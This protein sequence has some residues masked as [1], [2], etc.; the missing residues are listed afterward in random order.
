MQK[1]LDL[2]LFFFNQIDNTN[3]SKLIL[4][5]FLISIS[6]FL[7]F[8]SIGSIIPLLSSLL[9]FNDLE[10]NN[11]FYSI[12][13]LMNLYNKNLEFLIFFFIVVII[14]SSLFRILVLRFT[15]KTSSLI[16]SQLSSKMF[17][18][19]IY[20][21]YD[22]FITNESNALIGGITQKINALHSFILNLLYLISGIFLSIGI[23]FA[24]IFYNIE[25]TFLILTVLLSFFIIISFSISKKIDEFSKKN[26]FFVNKRIKFLQETIGSIK[27]IILNFAH[28]KILKLFDTNEK[29]YRLVDYKISF[30][31]AFP[32]I[33]VEAFGI[34]LLLLIS[35][36]YFN[37]SNNNKILLTLGVFS[38]AANRLLPII[39]GGYQSWA[40]LSGNY[41]F[42][43][44][45]SEIFSSKNEKNL[46]DYKKSNKIYQF[47]KLENLSFSHLNNTRKVFNGVNLKIPLES[48]KIAIIGPTG[49]GKSTF[50]N[51]IT[52]LLKPSSGKIFLDDQ[53][54]EKETLQYWQSQL[55]YVSQNI[56]LLNDT[57][58]NNITFPDDSEAISED[59]LN[60]VIKLVEIESFIANL[61]KGLETIIS[62]DG[63]NI[64][65][66]QKQRIGLARALYKKKKILL[67]D[68]ATNNLDYLTEEKIFTNI[69]NCSYISTI[70]MITH[71][72][73]N[74][75]KFDIIIELD[76]I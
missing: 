19:I 17:G 71:R 14:S 61:E 54:L 69:L 5:I 73:D 56:F 30:L 3:K 33:L 31:T 34:T 21:P 8:L 45:I 20:Q 58:K 50:L 64:S 48:K 47:L 52:G 53:N 66:G 49:V 39:N 7:E 26:S 32:R 16:I 42:F 51:L 55:S 40:I 57:I 27:E 10:N 15:I 72:K 63:K 24:L 62:E 6:S 76:K 25:V 29:N 43:K 23:F 12:L 46:Y 59:R 60:E 11:Y 67:L 35:L 44:D 4:L 65:G 13:S 41:Y 9:Q 68:E 74:L 70:I 36:F 38:Y 18:H 1:K 28:S 2:L 37:F 75:D 22:I